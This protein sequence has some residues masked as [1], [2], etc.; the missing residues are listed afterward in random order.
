M[1]RLR[2]VR[3]QRGHNYCSPR[4]L[5]A[6]LVIVVLFMLCRHRNAAIQE[7][8]SG[9]LSTS[10]LEAKLKGE[11]AGAVEHLQGVK[12]DKGAARGRLEGMKVPQ[13]RSRPTAYALSPFILSSCL[14]RVWHLE[15]HAHTF[16]H[17]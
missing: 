17:L 14:S 4:A 15:F 5:V 2:R 3:R 13:N 16:A 6:V 7:L 10:T 11:A 1:P 9:D 12:G 8:L